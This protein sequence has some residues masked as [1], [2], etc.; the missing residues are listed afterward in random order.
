MEIN[1]KRNVSKIL[2]AFHLSY[3][4]IELK[5]SKKTEAKKDVL[6]N[7]YSGILKSDSQFLTRWAEWD[8][9]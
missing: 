4:I 9:Q 7:Y 3:E 5:K 6:E 1:L 8:F 2:P